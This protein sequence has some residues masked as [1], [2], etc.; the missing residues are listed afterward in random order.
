MPQ[1]NFDRAADFVLEQEGGYVFDPSDPGGETKYGISRRSHPDIED[2]KELTIEDAKKIYK[3]EYWD[4]IR[5]DEL[6]YPAAL[7]FFDFAINSGVRSATLCIQGVLGVRQDGRIGRV[8]MA[9]LSEFPNTHVA[10][11]ICKSR[12]EFVIRLNN[13]RPGMTKFLVGWLKRI[14]AV[15]F[16]AAQG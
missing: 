3:E 6:P 9:A 8:T 14:I 15:S 4:P 5:G 12:A 13:V 10:Q 1:S 7:A 16:A 11:K 2:I